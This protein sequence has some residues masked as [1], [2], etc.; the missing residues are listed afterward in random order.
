MAFHAYVVRD[1]VQNSIYHQGTKVTKKSR[2]PNRSNMRSDVG[3]SSAGR[4]RVHLTFNRLSLAPKRDTGSTTKT[5]M[6]RR[7]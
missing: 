6:P 7:Q 4:K 3:S 5:R 2:R 1:R